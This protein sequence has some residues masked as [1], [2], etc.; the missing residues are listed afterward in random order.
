MWFGETLDSDILTEVEKEL[1]ICDLCLVVRDNSKV[2]MAL[3]YVT[4][5]MEYVHKLCRS[6]NLCSRLKLRNSVSE[7]RV[8]YT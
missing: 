5:I 3:E 1:E 6:I 8:A 4:K 7:K 2:T